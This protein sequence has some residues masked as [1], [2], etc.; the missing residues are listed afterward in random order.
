MTRIDFYII[1]Q[2]PANAAQLLACKLAEKAL[3]TGS[4]VYIHTDNAEQTDQ[5][6]QLLWSFE[7]T[8]FVPHDKADTNHQ[9]A[10]VTVGHG[11]PPDNQDAI[12]INLSGAL[13]PGY[14][15]FERVLELVP[16]DH[17]AR[18]R[19]RESFGHYR[20]RGYPINSHK[21]SL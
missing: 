1:E 8:S 7:A 5:L 11:A 13:P 15:R 4:A 6:D 20:D 16:P 3:K 9:P 14:S 10:P 17:E 2:G 21:I 18:A 12:L 19:L